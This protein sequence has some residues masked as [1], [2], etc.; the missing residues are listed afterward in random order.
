MSTLINP[1][2][3]SARPPHSIAP[4]T[5]LATP[6]IRP[7]RPT[8]VPAVLA[9]FDG[10]VSWLVANGRAGQWGSEPFSAIPK[11]VEQISGWAAGGTLR[12]AELRAQPAEAGQPAGRL[13]AVQATEPAEVQIRPGRADVNRSGT[14]VR[15]AGAVSIGA[16]PWFAPPVDEPELYL[17][18]LVTDR[19]P[20]GR[21]LGRALIEAAAGEAVA[22]RIGLLRVDCWAGGDGALVRYYERAGFTA[23][24][25]IKAGAWEGLVL[26]RRCPI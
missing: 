12:V 13:P 22:R 23:T 10:A 6:V 1:L 20:S 15:I 24:S 8:D 5:P 16:A 18:G 19:R 14:R 3:G 9:L 2:G 26:A 21:G 4:V 25:S 7:G 11:Q 17:Q